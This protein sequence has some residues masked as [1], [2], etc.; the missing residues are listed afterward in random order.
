M[1][2]KASWSGSNVVGHELLCCFHRREFVVAAI[3]VGIIV[4]GVFTVGGFVV[5]TRG[6]GRLSGASESAKQSISNRTS[7]RSL[8]SVSKPK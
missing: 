2:G 7:E 3:I 5:R 6:R 4:G 8:H 1:C